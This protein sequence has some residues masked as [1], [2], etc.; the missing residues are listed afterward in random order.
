MNVRSGIVMCV[1]S[2]QPLVLLIL[3][4]GE[5]AEESA[6]VARATGCMQNSITR[7]PLLGLAVRYVAKARARF[8]GIQ[9][10]KKSHGNTAHRVIRPTFIRQI[11]LNAPHEA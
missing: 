10:P 9:K 8:R 1:R 3:K 5:S 6:R 2:F 11:E 7:I 4:E